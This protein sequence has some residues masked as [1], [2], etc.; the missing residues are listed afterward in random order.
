MSSSLPSLN[1]NNLKRFFHK[2]D[3][4][5]NNA[6]LDEDE[7]LV[8]MI[9]ENQNKDD[10][11]TVQ[12]AE[13]IISIANTNDNPMLLLYEELALW[14]EKESKRTPEDRKV[15]SAKSS[16]ERRALAFME[17]M[18]HA[19]SA[20][21]NNGPAAPTISKEA[22]A[23][24][25]LPAIWSKTKLKQFYAQYDWSDNGAGL[26]DDELLQWMLQVNQNP[27]D[28]PT[29][30]DVEQLIGLHDISKNFMIDYFF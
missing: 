2:Y 14:M 1:R 26:D 5:D 3:W 18:M 25:E 22:A 12:D 15:S 27:E 8:W 11:P 7:L 30:A 19:C 13:Y 23:M 29:S 21:E 20:D 16:A 4:S 28:P 6:G 17:H 9:D 24:V 10:P